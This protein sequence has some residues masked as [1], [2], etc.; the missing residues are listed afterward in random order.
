MSKKLH[1]LVLDAAGRSPDAI[2][3]R[4]R[5]RSLDYATLAAQILQVAS[6]LVGLGLGR[7]ER[8]GVYLPKQMESVVAMFGA[9]AAGCTF[10]PVNPVL[11]P[12][13]V[14][15][16][17][18]DCDVRVLVTSRSRC[19]QLAEELSQCPSLR[20]LVLVDEEAGAEPLPGVSMLGWGSLLQATGAEAHRVIDTDMVSIFYTS[21]STGRPKGV[22]LSHRNMVTGAQSV[23]SYLGNTPEDRLLAVLPFSFDYG[24]SQLS[25]AFSAGASVALLDYLLPRDV[26]RALARYQITGLAGVP[27]LWIQL[28]DLRWPEGVDSHLRY[29]TNS[30]GAMPRATL[31]RLRAN[32]PRS[33]FFLMYGLTEAFRSTFL[34]P[35]EVDSRPDSIGKAIPN[36][37]ILVLRPDGSPCDA[38]EPGELVHRGSLVAL[39]YWNDREKTAE[40]FKPIPPQSSG[41]VLPELAVWSGDTVRR[42]EEGY[43]YFVGRRDEMIKTS[44]YRVSPTEIEEAAYATGLVGD[45]VAAG[46]PHPKLGQ[47]VVLIAS[48]PSG[49]HGDTEGLL[50][51]LRSSLPNFM[52]PAAVI[53]MPELPR[54]PNG[55]FDRPALA[56]RVVSRFAEQV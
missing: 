48:P 38:N 50:Q 10:V 22:V 17:L 16:I 43:L 5:D 47:G 1:E 36:A 46:A 32:A 45:A 6:G 56:A 21:G 26:I 24:F 49:G 2:A 19:E 40:R 28:A 30:G 35:E 25:T 39:G 31:A 20:H 54:N 8:V 37:E 34:P 15:H 44:G 13:Q 41:L 27:P 4:D 14:G 23:A 53:W 11:K 18:R 42:D 7:S 29:M 9:A 3:L 33:R 12:S 55:K 52:V 51:A